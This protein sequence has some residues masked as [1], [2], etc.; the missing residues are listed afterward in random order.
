[1]PIVPE[2]SAC[3]DTGVPLVLKDPAGEVS[4]LYG[5]IAAKVVQEVAKLQLGPRGGLQID[6][7]GVAGVP[8]AL[9]VMLVDEGGLPFYVRAVDV[10][11]RYV[12][13]NGFPKLKDRLRPTKTDTFFY[14]S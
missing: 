4:S 5:A 9:K 8:G 2:L 13:N 6:D 3:G 1:M 10:R 12:W 7:A 14:L 11:R